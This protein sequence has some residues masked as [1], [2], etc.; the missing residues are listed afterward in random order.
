MKRDLGLAFRNKLVAGHD[1][2]NKEME[3]RAEAR[4]KE[5]AFTEAEKAQL[6]QEILNGQE[7]GAK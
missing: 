6:E 5:A 2:V 3:A 4:E 7:R 1:W